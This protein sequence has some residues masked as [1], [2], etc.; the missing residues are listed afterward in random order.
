M[1]G[2]LNFAYMKDSILPWF[3]QL[4]WLG[5]IFIGG[6]L[7]G[8]ALYF[9]L[10]K[11]L[12]VSNSELADDLRRIKS[13]FVAMVIVIA[14]QLWPE[15]YFESKTPYISQ[16]SQIVNIM[17]VTWLLIGVT[18]GVRD[19]IVRRYENDKNSDD[20]KLRKLFTQVRLFERIIIVVIIILAIALILMTFDSIK[21][22]GYSILTSAG[23]AGIIIGLAAQR[24][25]AN[26]LAGFQLAV[27]QP[28]R[29][30]D[31]V[32]VEGEWGKVHEMTLTYVVIAI[33]DKRTLVVPSTYFIE[34]PFQNWTRTSADLLGTVFLYLD[35]RM[36][37]EP[38]RLEQTRILENTDLWD[39]KVNIIQVTD[40]TEKAMQVR[41]LV[42]AKD[43]PTAWDLRVHLREKMI[44]FLQR[45]H[46]E[47][48][49]K[50]RI[51]LD[52]KNS[53]TKE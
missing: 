22:I 2:H 5:G 30:G 42:S 31:V 37:L 8:L 23:I 44:A 36:P 14:L 53:P 39:G 27:T 25:I 45:E 13:P 48:L 50:N 33:W 4:V 21:R 16:L 17:A 38:M 15:L 28:I 18:K 9:L 1:R 49:P 51:V 24:L 20:L 7:L 32:I 19:S 52:E 34:K 26:L 47:M 29:L 35:Y 11:A 3:E 46:P 10:K 40:S 43:S 12:R 6:L 41:L